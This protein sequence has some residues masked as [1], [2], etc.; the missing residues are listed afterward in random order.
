M[1]QRITNR[2]SQN[3]PLLIPLLL[4]IILTILIWQQDGGFIDL[5][6]LVTLFLWL[7]FVGY[8]TIF[9]TFKF[10]YRSLGFIVGIVIAIGIAL[11]FYLFQH[12]ISI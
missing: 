2:I 3:L 6:P 8:T 10:S 12:P 9:L 11:L 5:R 1:K 7:I 4:A